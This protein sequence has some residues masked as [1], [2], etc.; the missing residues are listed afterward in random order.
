M[1]LLDQVEA[2]NNHQQ[3]VLVVVHK[4]SQV[5]IYKNLQDMLSK[6][7]RLVVLEVVE[8]NQQVVK[9][10]EALLIKT[11]VYYLVVVVIYH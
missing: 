5:Q 11:E 6:F 7:Q 2:D 9:E 3:V 4:A 8:V 10:E 1:V